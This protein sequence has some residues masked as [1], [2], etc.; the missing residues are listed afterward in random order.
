MRTT[1]LSAAAAVAVAVLAVGC[2]DPA[3]PDA[4]DPDSSTSG[5]PSVPAPPRSATTVEMESRGTAGTQRSSVWFRIAAEAELS[6]GEPSQQGTGHCSL[7]PREGE[8]AVPVTLTLTHPGD[9]DAADA[10]D[11]IAVDDWPLDSA[12]AAVGGAGPLMWSEDRGDECTEELDLDALTAEWA[13]RQQRTALGEVILPAD[14][15]G[16]GAGVEVDFGGSDPERTEVRGD[17]PEP[18]SATY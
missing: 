6:L 4:P 2:S 12:A 1:P 3:T 15:H 14:P 8:A 16:T 17:V 7:S 18:L 13:P 5:T 9:E 10:D 11:V